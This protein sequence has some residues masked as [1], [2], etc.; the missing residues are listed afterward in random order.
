MNL[1]DSFGGGGGFYDDYGFSPFHPSHSYYQRQHQQRAR[2]IQRQRA[3]E[4]ERRRRAAEEE[5][6]R[7]RLVYHQALLE[8]QRRAEEYERQRRLALQREEEEE[9]L[10]RQQILRARA[11]AEAERRAKLKE[12]EHQRLLRQKMTQ[13]SSRTAFVRGP[14]GY[15]YRVILD[16]DTSSEEESMH[17]QPRHQIQVKEQPKRREMI[18]PQPME[19]ESMHSTSTSSTIYHDAI[20]DENATVRISNKTAGDNTTQKVHKKKSCKNSKKGRKKNRKKI[21]ITVED[22]SDSEYD[23]DFS[24]PWRN[25]RPGPGESWIEPVEQ[26][27]I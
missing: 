25:R 6:R 24:S 22:A 21:T 13:P 3:I 23:D 9:R 2:E 15:L 1:F 12:A 10:R 19:T 11:E 16:D 17:E 14:D 18:Y 5:E 7:R 27:Y 26:H 8:R 20:D 4:A